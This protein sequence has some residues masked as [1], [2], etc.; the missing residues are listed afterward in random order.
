MHGATIKIGTISG[1]HIVRVYLYIFYSRDVLE[2][3][4]CSAS[5]SNRP[6]AHP[7]DYTGKPSIGGIKT[8][9]G[10]SKC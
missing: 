3:K 9:R 8:S 4:L 2:V 1:L 10:R 7:V 5:A 6:T